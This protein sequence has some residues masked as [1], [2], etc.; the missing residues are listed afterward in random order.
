M[1]QPNS[2]Q[3]LHIFRRPKSIL[4]WAL[5]FL[6]FGLIYAYEFIINH[7]FADIFPIHI[8]GLTGRFETLFMICSISLPISTPLEYFSHRFVIYEDKLVEVY[9]PFYTNT[10][11]K[12]DY[13]GYN[14][15]EVGMGKTNLIIMGKSN[16]KKLTFDHRKQ[17]PWMVNYLDTNFKPKN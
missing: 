2:T 4:I 11:A 16:S 10:L 7:R 1:S 8:D 13:L 12:N 14:F 3:P 17:I 5:V 15:K 9:A 6:P